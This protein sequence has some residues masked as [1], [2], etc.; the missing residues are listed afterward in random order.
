[1]PAILAR[2]FKPLAGTQRAAVVIGELG[3]KSEKHRDKTK[4]LL[5]L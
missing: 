5:L 3:H 1:M 4:G 2:F